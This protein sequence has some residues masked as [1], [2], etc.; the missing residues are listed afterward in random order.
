MVATG[1]VSET[2]TGSIAG[3]SDAVGLTEFFVAATIVALVG[4]A[5]EHGTAVIVAAKGNVELGIEVALR[6]SA[7]VAAILIPAVALL[8]WLVKPLPLAFHPVELVAFAGSAALAAAL[9]A[10]ARSDRLRG[11][12]LVAAYPVVVLAFLLTHGFR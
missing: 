12:A 7:Q 4:N 2:V 1:I 11:V 6:S 5:A 9:L 8:S 3:F 10:R